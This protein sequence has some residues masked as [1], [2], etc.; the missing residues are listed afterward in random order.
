MS[1]L[2]SETGTRKIEGKISSQKWRILGIW[3]FKGFVS[4]GVTAWRIEE[5]I[6][7]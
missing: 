7:N 6:G 3:W 2:S 5:V 1:T 4:D